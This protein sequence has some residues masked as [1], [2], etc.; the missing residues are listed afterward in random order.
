MKAFGEDCISTRSTLTFANRW[1]LGELLGKGTFGEVYT[2]SSTRNPGDVRAVKILP[3]CDER[4]SGSDPAQL[5]RMRSLWREIQIMLV[6]NRHPNIVSIED[7]FDEGGNIMIVMEQ[8]TGGDLFERIKDSSLYSEAVARDVVFHVLCAISHC[9]S[10]NVVHRDLKPENI[11]ISEGSDVM[12]K[13]ADFGNAT[14]IQESSAPGQLVGM[15]GSEGY[16]APEMIQG[17]LYG[18]AV[19]IWSLG[20]ITYVLLCGY[21]PWNMTAVQRPI[22]VL[23]HYWPMEDYEGC[24]E[25]ERVWCDV[26]HDA[27]DFVRR[28][29]VV[30]PSKRITADEALQHPWILASAADLAGRKL[31]GAVSRL[32]RFNARRRLSAVL[33]SVLASHLLARQGPSPLPLAPPPMGNGP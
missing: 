13:L 29:L 12:I 18:K 8:A 24:P 19:D 22:V 33:K 3:K 20:V 14:V 1:V 31:A 10:R 7:Y 4:Q 17:K 11:L 6:I 16:M 9:H 27:K 32:R 23:G 21:P 26:S 15:A 25:D 5:L 2:C 28:A 30:E